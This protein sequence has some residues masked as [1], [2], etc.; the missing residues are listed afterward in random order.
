MKEKIII[1]M[2]E[3]FYALSLA[4]IVFGVMEAL[5]ARSILNYF[6]LDILLIVWLVNA[7]IL[8]IIKNKNIKL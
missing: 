6:N 1:V 4:M 5:K 2:E 8:L 7:I 3:L